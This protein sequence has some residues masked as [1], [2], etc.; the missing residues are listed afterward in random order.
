MHK[1]SN[2]LPLP[3]L[4]IGGAVLGYLAAWVLVHVLA[5]LAWIVGPILGILWGLSLY[6]KPIR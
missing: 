3:V 2:S 6:K 4:V 5:S 1:N